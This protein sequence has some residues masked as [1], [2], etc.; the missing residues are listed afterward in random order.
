M[1]KPPTPVPEETID[2][3]LGR[4]EAENLAIVEASKTAVAESKGSVRNFVFG[5]QLG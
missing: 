3:A 1:E 5:V 2:H 4:M